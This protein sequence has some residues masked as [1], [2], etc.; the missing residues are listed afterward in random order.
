MNAHA[1]AVPSPIASLFPVRSAGSGPESMSLDRYYRE[2]R[3]HFLEPQSI[4]GNLEVMR[5]Q[6]LALW[7]TH[8]EHDWDASS[9]EAISQRDFFTAWNFLDALP[10]NIARP[11]F[12]PEPNGEI[13]LEWYVNPNQ[14]FVVSI[15]RDGIIT[16]AG[17]YGLNKRVSGA[18]N[19]D[20]VV[21]AAVLEGI[22]R[23]YRR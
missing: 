15:G 11:D 2:V 19:F 4:G 18:E 12:V 17:R 16:F 1:M 21:P 20:G 8:A 13:A 7:E 5:A 14:V 10:P 9:A 6:L 3:R 22:D 23:V